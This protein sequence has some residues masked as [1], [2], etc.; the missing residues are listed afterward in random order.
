MPC[1]TPALSGIGTCQISTAASQRGSCLS[2]ENTTTCPVNSYEILRNGA[3]HQPLSM[4]DSGSLLTVNGKHLISCLMLDDF[5]PMNRNDT[6][7]VT[8]RVIHCGEY[9]ATM[10]AFD[11]QLLGVS[12]M[13]PVHVSWDQDAR[14]YLNGSLLRWKIWG[15]GHSLPRDWSPP[16]ISERH[17]GHFGPCFTAIL[18]KGMCVNR[19]VQ[20]GLETRKMSW[21]G[22]ANTKWPRLTTEN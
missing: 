20:K 15:I 4:V 19:G 22:L 16:E 17:G 2:H 3:V 10:L 14:Q 12:Q 21:C 8:V 9:E 6:M 5:Y 7:T 18:T 1:A 13:I 11:L